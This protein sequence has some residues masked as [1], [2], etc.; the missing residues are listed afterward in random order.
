MGGCP[1]PSRPLPVYIAPPPRGEDIW[2][3]LPWPCSLYIGCGYV[4]PAFL[5]GLVR[6]QQPS[7]EMGLAGPGHAPLSCVWSLPPSGASP[8][9]SWTAHWGVGVAGAAGGGEGAGVA[10]ERGAR[11]L[12][13][14]AAALHQPRPR[15][16]APRPQAI[17]PALS[18]IGGLVPSH[19]LVYVKRLGFPLSFCR[20]ARREFVGWGEFCL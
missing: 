6:W 4:R 8:L 5:G 9:S 20:W 13:G 18:S 3:P 1:W 19:Q 14:N 17:P 10:G 16:E 11:P 2:G 7:Q 12:L 15:P